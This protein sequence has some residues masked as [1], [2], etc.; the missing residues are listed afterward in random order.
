MPKLRLLIAVERIQFLA[1][2]FFEYFGFPCQFSFHQIH[3]QSG[4][5]HLR[6]EYQE[7]VSYF[8]IRAQNEN[9]IAGM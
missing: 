3:Y 4:I 9:K 2:D 1:K 6:P 5:V 8:T 7:S